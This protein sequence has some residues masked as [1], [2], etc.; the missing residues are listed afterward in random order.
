MRT[1]RHA[2][3]LGVIALALAVAACAASIAPATLTPPASPV[4]SI[5]PTQ[6]P[7]AEASG[8]PSP[9]ITPPPNSAPSQAPA[10]PTVY[11]EA[12]K[13][14]EGAHG[15]APLLDFPAVV[16]VD[17]TAV[18][19]CDFTLAFQPPLGPT[20]LPVISAHVAGRRTDTVKVDLVPGSYYPAVGE[21][22]GCTDTVE[23]RAP[24]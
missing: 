18:G 13:N 24:G 7:A 10:T 8:I 1:L 14:A 6:M 22:V 2:A 4:P 9:V 11:Y 16:I 15:G 12:T 5:A 21:A 17:Y 19:T 20:V 3:L 23:I